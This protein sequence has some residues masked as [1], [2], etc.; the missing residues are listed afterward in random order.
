MKPDKNTMKLIESYRVRVDRA[1]KLKNKA[2]ELSMKKGDFVKEP[3]LISYLI[4]KYVESIT[5]EEIE[6]HR[7]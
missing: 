7:K 6:K 2:F 4:D 1:E 5:L 3:E